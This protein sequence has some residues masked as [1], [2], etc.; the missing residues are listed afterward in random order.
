MQRAVQLFSRLSECI[1]RFVVMLV[2]LLLVSMVVV[3]TLQVIC[4]VFFSALTWSEELSRYLLVW[5]TFF[6]ST[7]AYKRGNHIAVTFLVEALP[8]RLSAAVSLV[9]YLL[10]MAFFLFAANYAWQMI[11]MQI[12]QI[13]PAMGLSMRYVYFSLPTSMLIMVVH[14]LRGMLIQLA[15]MSGKEAA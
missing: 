14:A 6:A 11:S 12:F 2:F 7:M 8:K 10:S 13:S 15:V 9:S 5:S 4:R 3:T 1:D